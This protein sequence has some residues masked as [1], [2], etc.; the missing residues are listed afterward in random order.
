MC[1]SHVRFGPIADIGQLLLD[2]LLELCGLLDRK[3]SWSRTLED[4]IDIRG[5]TAVQIGIIRAIRDQ[6]TLFCCYRPS[7]YR[8][9]AMVH[10]GINE[11][12]SV[13]VR[14]RRGL[15]DERQRVALLHLSENVIHFA[16]VAKCSELPIVACPTGW[17]IA[18][19][20]CSGLQ[21][22]R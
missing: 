17:R 19:T 15:N 21:G 13:Q 1:F 10:R 2:H 16:D 3:F 6:C 20:Y 18:H 22:H 14:E 4:S 11:P 12:D 8:P 9:K 7:E 5:S